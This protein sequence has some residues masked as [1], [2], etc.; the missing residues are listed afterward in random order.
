[1][2]VLVKILNRGMSLDKYDEIAPRLVPEL[3]RQ[4]GFQMHLCSSTDDGLVVHEVWDTAGQQ[5]AWFEKYVRPNLPP[6]ARSEIEVVE[7]HNVEAK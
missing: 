6:E 5:Q 1:M 3:K 4:S 7:L 2:A